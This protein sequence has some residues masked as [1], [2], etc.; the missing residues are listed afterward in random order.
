MKIFKQYSSSWGSHFDDFN[1]IHINVFGMYEES[2][3][4]G[5]SAHYTHEGHCW[6]SNPEPWDRH[7]N[8]KHTVQ[9]VRPKIVVYNFNGTF[10][11]NH[12]SESAHPFAQLFPVPCL[13]LKLDALSYFHLPDLAVLLKFC[14]MTFGSMSI[15]T[16]LAT[17]SS[18]C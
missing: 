4:P 12:K 7:L 14:L 10:Y 15:S 11:I 5:E 13:W 8:H 6:D 9:P 3:V 1:E 17:C 18:E 16:A 2:G